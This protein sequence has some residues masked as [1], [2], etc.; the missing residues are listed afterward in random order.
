MRKYLLASTCFMTFA[1]PAL[2]GTT[3]S[4]TVTGPIK[5]STV[6]QGAADDIIV[7]P[8]GIVN[9]TAAGGVI[10][11]SNHKL[12]NQG[13]I[14]IGG[15]NNAVGV[16]AAAGVTSGITLSGKIIVDEG[17]TPTDADREAYRTRRD[18]LKARLADALA[19]ETVAV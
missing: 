12:D 3:I 8:A 1:G 16:D 14:Q 17:Y 13:T 19:K 9:G 5:T 2:A 7:G 18:V 15:I 11:D 6:K 4:T 10:I